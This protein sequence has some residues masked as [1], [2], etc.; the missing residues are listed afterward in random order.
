MIQ[1][2]LNLEDW[3]PLMILME[4]HLSIKLSLQS[5]EEK[6]NGCIYT[7]SCIATKLELLKYCKW[8]KLSMRKV[9]WFMGPYHNVGITFAALLFTRTKNNFCIQIGNQNETNE[10][11]KQNFYDLQKIYQNHERF[12]PCTF[13]H[14]Q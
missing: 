8:Q 12:L 5:L 6:P 11:S 4:K 3:S 1:T 13:Y 7:H 10:I 14:L 2:N 9:S